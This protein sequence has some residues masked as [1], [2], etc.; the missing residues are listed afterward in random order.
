VGSPADAPAE[1]SSNNPFPLGA[2]RATRVTLPRRVLQ[3][4]W[5]RVSGSLSRSDGAEFRIDQSLL[6][7]SEPPCETSHS[8][9]ECFF[10]EKVSRVV[11]G[12]VRS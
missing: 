8:V 11:F 2:L 3:A 4:V 9:L 1:T 5:D 10:K 7:V 12:A 6:S